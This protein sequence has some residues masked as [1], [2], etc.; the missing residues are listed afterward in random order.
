MAS[1]DKNTM[2]GVQVSLSRRTPGPA[3]PLPPGSTARTSF[4]GPP[5]GASTAPGQPPTKV[6]YGE[7]EKD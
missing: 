7:N 5:E 3:Y 4:Y 1:E 2:Q 6:V